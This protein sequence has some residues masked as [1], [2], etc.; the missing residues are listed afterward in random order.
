MCTLERVPG[1]GSTSTDCLAEWLVVNPTNVPLL[2]GRGRTRRRQRCVD[3]D[4]ACDFDG[5]VAG[6]CTFH[7]GVCA[8]DTDV[9]GCVP[10]ALGAYQL[11]KPSLAQAA[12]H[13]ELAA[14]RAA[15]AGVPAA[16]TGTPPDACT[17]PLDV[18]VPLRGGPGSYKTG[19]LTLGS[20]A[21]AGSRQDKDTL[22]LI[23]LP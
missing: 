7:V 8:N 16:V 19:K 18:V 15:F 14:V 12:R 17:A 9:P 23:C 5:G 20:I 3:N 10:A 21:T 4:P 6:A 11:A 1:G 2:D 13:P 22:K